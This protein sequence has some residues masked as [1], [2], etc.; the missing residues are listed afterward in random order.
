MVAIKWFVANLTHLSIPLYHWCD[1]CFLQG[2]DVIGFGGIFLVGKFLM[3]LNAVDSTKTG[4]TRFDFFAGCGA[5]CCLA[6]LGVIAADVA[7]LPLASF[8]S[9]VMA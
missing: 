6:W 4:F 1:G 5:V 3:L 9:P 8:D 7:R 2:I